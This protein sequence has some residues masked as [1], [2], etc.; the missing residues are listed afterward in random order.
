MYE[1]VHE[2][3]DNPGVILQ[4]AKIKRFQQRYFYFGK[5]KCLSWP[6]KTSFGC[7]ISFV[8]NQFR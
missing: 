1:N 7:K 6:S 4:K 5:V 3:Y 8:N 2:I